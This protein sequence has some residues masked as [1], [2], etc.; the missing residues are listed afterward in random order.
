MKK[1]NKVLKWLA[2]SPFATAVKVGLG[3]ALTWILDNV[4]AFNFTPATSAIIIAVTTI[5]INAL[6]P[7]DNRYGLKD[8]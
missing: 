8:Q 7:A 5:L 2:T 1:Q 6:N 4:G 3:A